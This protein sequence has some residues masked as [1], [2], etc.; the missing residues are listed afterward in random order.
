MNPTGSPA[1][2]AGLLRTLLALRRYVAAPLPGTALRVCGFVRPEAGRVRVYLV[3]GAADGPG[4]T[5]VDLPVRTPD[6]RSQ[7]PW[8]YVGALCE[9]ALLLGE[10]HRL[11]PA[12][13][14]DPFCRRAVDAVPL[15]A[16]GLLA[17]EVRAD[18]DD[19]LD[20]VIADLGGDPLWHGARASVA[21]DL[22]TLT[23]FV[24][25][26]PGV[27]RVHLDHGGRRI[28]VD[29]AT[30]A[31]DG[32]PWVPG[33][34]VSAKLTAVLGPRDAATLAAHRDRSRSAADPSCEA[35]YDLTTWA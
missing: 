19:A 25:R 30:S 3:G 4:A 33:W 12:A 27:A 17:Q 20:Y 34:W 14:T 35:V 2:D 23:G 11:L 26:A 28:G 18:V 24:R 6:G 29:L 32:R 7:P 15:L 5:A 8:W 22:Y 16:A 9:L 21:P 1:A 31:G 10:S 13:P